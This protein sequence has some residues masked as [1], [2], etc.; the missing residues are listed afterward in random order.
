[1]PKVNDV[2]LSFKSGLAKG[3][4]LSFSSAKNR[5]IGL[6]LAEHI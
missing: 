1:M 4:H 5:S 3:E 6:G 2:F